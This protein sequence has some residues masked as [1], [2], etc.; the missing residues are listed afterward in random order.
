MKYKNIENLIMAMAQSKDSVIRVVTT[1]LD[2]QVS[3]LIQDEE[4]TSLISIAR[5][6]SMIPEDVM[7]VCEK[8]SGSDNVI[9]S[10]QAVIN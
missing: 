9:K 7:I 5:F 10:F 8:K 4:G 2:G 3:L 6:E 1:E